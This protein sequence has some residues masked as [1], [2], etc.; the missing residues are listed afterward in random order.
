[1]GFSGSQEALGKHGFRAL[2][3]A[4]IA[5]NRGTRTV[6]FTHATTGIEAGV[7]TSRVHPRTIVIERSMRA[8]ILSPRYP[9]GR[10]PA[11]SKAHA[12]NLETSSQPSL[13]ATPLLTRV[14]ADAARW[15]DCRGRFGN[16]PLTIKRLEVFRSMPGG[17]V[18]H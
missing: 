17:R 13:Q 18:A 1:M 15:V 5:C 11:K 3:V 6:S 10:F 16:N 9:S 14:L 2:H 12:P 7:L 8:P 4:K